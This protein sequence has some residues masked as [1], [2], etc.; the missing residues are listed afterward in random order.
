MDYPGKVSRQNSTPKDDF[1]NAA[2]T[3]P[4][5]S[6]PNSLAGTSVAV[7]GPLP[8]NH[9][10]LDATTPGPNGF[11]TPP[12]NTTMMIGKCMC[13]NSNLRFPVS[14][15]CFRCTVCQT[16]NDLKPTQ[17]K[18][19]PVTPLTL[20]RLRAMINTCRSNNNGRNSTNYD[21]LEQTIQKCFS[22][23]YSLNESFSNASFEHITI[24]STIRR[25]LSSANCRSVTLEDCGVALDQ[26][27]DAY[28][29][30]LELDIKKKRRY[31]VFDDYT[32]KSSTIPTQFSTR[33]SIP[34]QHSKT[35]STVIFRRRVDLVN[36]FISF[37]LSKQQR[38][39]APNTVLSPAYET[40]W[41]IS[42]AAR[43]MALLFAANKQSYKIPLSEFYNTLVDYIDLIADFNTWEQ[44]SSKFAFCQYPFLI[45]MGGKITIMEFD[46][47]RQMET[48]AK[49]A[50]FTILFQKRV[51]A[52]HL[53][54]RVR[55]DFLIEDSL[56]QI[57]A[58]EME[59]KKSLRIEFV[60]EDGVDAGGLRKEW[61]LLLVRELFDPRYGMFTWDE[62]S[63][64]CWFNPASFETSDQYY[65]VGVVIGLAIYNST[66][67]D[68][69]F[70]L[71]CYKKLFNSPVGLE[72]LKVF[73][74]AFARGLETLLTF[75]GDVETTFCRDFVGEYEAFGELQRIPLV[76]GG[77]NKPVTNANRKDYVDRYVNFILNDSI[78][79]QFEPFK[80]GFNHVCGGNAL[81][82]FQPEEIELLVRGSAEPLEIEQLR[83]VTVY[84]GFREDEEIIKNFW[85]IF[86]SMD[87][88]M[89]RKLLTFVTGTDRIPA[90]GLANLALKISCLGDDSERYRSRHKLQSKL[91]R[92]I[93]ESEGF[94]LK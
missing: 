88:I 90:T 71:A 5:L 62:D 69:H 29:I 92:A 91:Q 37:R 14:V 38:A 54:L 1:G 36:A 74:P 23:W 32:R 13:C 19:D 45:S 84:E 17:Q 87:P 56:N 59:L 30:L 57:A 2:T 81:S 60:G 58:N 63:N 41:R 79:K 7:P 12:S 8:A 48:K 94:G 72:D 51:T 43:V 10:S 40:D 31:Q 34:P 11:S 55:R 35:H 3:S 52:P 42:S 67:L 65:L 6:R 22:N 75:E 39:Q 21:T 64:L 9:V 27:R 18:G 49:E 82:L 83:A 70:P 24:I 76:P 28:R 89:Q 4:S 26:V 68:V 15:S 93:E 78:S 77:E 80:R 44:R 61:F 16:I 47:K 33:V 50:F 53:I 85:S 86:K 25:F 66:I 46:A 20:D 73:R